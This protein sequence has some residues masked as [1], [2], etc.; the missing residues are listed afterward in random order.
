[1]VGGIHP[2]K[3]CLPVAKREH[4][5]LALREAAISGDSRFFLGTDSAPHLDQAKECASGCAGIFSVPVCLSILAHVFEEEGALDKLEAFT[6]LYGPQFYQLE[7][8][9]RWTILE[10][11]ETPL[12]F[13]E[14]IDRWAEVVDSSMPRY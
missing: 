14:Y 11:N 6:S 8:N 12:N 4:H 7:P 10:K 5:R 13:P 1:L 2:H 9:E 3:Y